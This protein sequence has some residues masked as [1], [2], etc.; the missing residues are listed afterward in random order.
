MQINS[1]NYNSKFHDK[2]IDAAKN[3]D[4]NRLIQLIILEIGTLEL[5]AVTTHL[6][7]DVLQ[8]EKY[9]SPISVAERLKLRRK[10]MMNRGQDD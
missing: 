8:L 7:S 2:L 1:K 4:V 9:K 6:L 10:L 3:Y 5:D